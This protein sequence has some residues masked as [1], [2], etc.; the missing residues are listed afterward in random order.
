MAF[1]IGQRG[2]DVLDFV[3]IL[4]KAD[5]Q[6]SGVCRHEP[7]LHLRRSR[8]CPLT[9]LHPAQISAHCR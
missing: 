7:A 1:V 4:A 9:T 3:E 6:G 8:W 2:D 5:I